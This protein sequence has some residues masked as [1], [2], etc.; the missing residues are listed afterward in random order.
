VQARLLKAATLA[1]LVSAA[2]SVRAQ[3]PPREPH[4]FISWLRQVGST[5]AQ[6]PRA[7]IGAHHLSPPLPRPRPAELAAVALQAEPAS[8]GRNTAE[9]ESAHEQAQPT[10]PAAVDDTLAE[11]AQAA[12]ASPDAP[13]TVQAEPASPAAPKK[14]KP[15]VP[16]N[17]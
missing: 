7:A 11:P 2:A 8:A 10:S 9:S 17:D 5:G 1:F 6:H 3:T 4:D 13:N 14:A 16:I 15:A 12:P